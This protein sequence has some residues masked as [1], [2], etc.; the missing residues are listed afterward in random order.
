MQRESDL[1]ISGLCHSVQG[2]AEMLAKWAG[3]RP[4]SVDYLCAGINHLSW[5]IKFER[6]GR[7]LYPRIRKAVESDAA[8]Y[9]NK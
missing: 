2:T 1:K 6:N 4:A 9:N 7:D 8:I 3:A 5:F